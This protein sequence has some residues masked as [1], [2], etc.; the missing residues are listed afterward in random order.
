MALALAY[1]DIDNFKQI[2]DSF[3]HAVGDGVLAEVARRLAGAVRR[4]DTVA[5]LAGDEFV[6]VLEQVGSPLECERIAAKLLE[7]I[8][9][10]FEV[11][12]RKL[13]VTT[14]IGIAW[15]PRP[16]QAALMHAADDALYQSKRIGRDTATVRALRSC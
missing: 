2:N 3:G 11:E 5:R 1:L 16:E 13:Q 15:C 6:I 12:G 14:S 8:R 4:T 7:A 10:G 9:P